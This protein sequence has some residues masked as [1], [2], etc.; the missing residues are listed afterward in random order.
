M[1][2]ILGW[3]PASRQRQHLTIKA[4]EEEAMA[5]PWPGHSSVLI[6]GPVD[7]NCSLHGGRWWVAGWWVGM[8]VVPPLRYA[9]LRRVSHILSS[10][11]AYRPPHTHL[12]HL[13]CPTQTH[14]NLAEFARAEDLCLA[15][16]WWLFNRCLKYAWDWILIG[17]NGRIGLVRGNWAKLAFDLQTGPITDWWKPP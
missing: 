9:F 17:G 13:N 14:L 16:I 3:Y 5:I 8:V 12:G 1:D 15:L 7:N 6:L 10:P 4:S 11:P 2:R